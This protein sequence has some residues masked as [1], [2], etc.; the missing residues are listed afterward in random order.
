MN[1]KQKLPVTY[2]LLTFKGRI[3]RITYWLASIFMWSNFYVFI[4]TLNY[5]FGYTSTLLVYPLMLWGILA[6]ST[7]RL[8]D[9][10]LRGRWFNLILIPVLG[11]IILIY[12]L[13]FR[14][15]NP[16]ENNFGSV[17]GSAVDYYKNDE[18]EKIPHLKT[19]EVIINDITKLNPVLVD[20]VFAPT[21]E[22]ELVEKIKN[23]KGIISVGGGRF[24]MGGQTASK[25]SLHIDMRNLNQVLNLDVKNKTIRVQAGIRWCDI[26]K[27]I[28]PENLSLKVMQT[29][30]NFTV[31]GSLSVNVHG[32]YIGLGSL[33]HVTKEIKILLADGKILIANRNENSEIFFGAIGSYNSIGIILEAEFELTENIS[34]KRQT[35]T[36]NI[37]EYNQYFKYAIRDDKK[38]IFHNADIYPTKY[39][40]LR[41]VSWLYT[42]EKPNEKN[43]LMPLKEDYPIHRTLLWSLTEFQFGNKLREYIIDP[44]IY[45]K[46]K[47]H[48]RNYEAGYDV[49]ELEPYSRKDSTYVLLEY[50]VP[51]ENFTSFVEKVT[52]I[53]NRYQVNM[54]NISVR[55]AHPDKETY[56]SWAREEAFAFVMYYKQKVGEVEKN[57]VATWTRE[58]IQAAIDLGGSY[59]LPYQAHASFEQFTKAYPNYKKL[60]ELK[61]KLDPEFRFRNIIWDTYYKN[62]SEELK[63]DSDFKKVFASFDLRDGIYKFL[64]VIFH[65][66]PEEKFH[67][68]IKEATEKFQTDKEIYEY[69][70]THLPSI[71]PFLG[72]VT[73]ALPSL[74]KQKKEIVS[75]TLKFL[76]DKKEI[77]GYLEIGSTGRYIS[78]LKNKLK[79]KNIYLISDKL[80]TNSLPDIFERGGIKKI[81]TSIEL[82]NYAPITKI[83]ES[84]LELV[85]CYIG[86]HHSPLENLQKFIESIYK[87]L[88]PGGM[89]ILRDHDVKSEEMFRF[90]SL[91]HTIFNAGL[92]DSHETELADFKKFRSLYEWQSMLEKIGFQSGKEKIL[93]KNDPTDNTLIYFTKG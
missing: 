59:Y 89:F 1:F 13:A 21:N 80:P 70:R 30:A 79:V 49:A 2:L 32:R 38:V 71:K 47:I 81:G 50:F 48:F 60:F 42:T 28:D 18:G 77:D 34:V 54:V 19:N 64:Q 67:Y 69:L 72:D 62:I 22:S 93:Q 29:Y 86:L 53:L 63:T 76:K 73:L 7:K 4:K 87:I 45:L 61:E 8:H 55:H 11:P 10:G 84:S 23:T 16:K 85:T 82:N 83:P 25:N 65:L 39:S 12:L 24:S 14:K 46:K 6:V 91:V 44:F 33:V 90:V 35:V 36:L 66:Y 3:D 88:K 57:V 41:A 17:Q 52:E 56:M 75:Q 51:V 26:Q 43:R 78:Y 27:I 9:I 68:M 74:L 15:G 58:L 37:K 40:K 92:G 31:G 5:F 20:A